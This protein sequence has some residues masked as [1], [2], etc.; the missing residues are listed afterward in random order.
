MAVAGEIVIELVADNGKMKMAV[1]DAQT[2]IRQFETS[3][4]QTARSVKRL[5]DAQFSLSTKFR[6]LVMTLGNL[7]FAL[8]DINDVFIRLPANIMKNAGELERLQTLMKGLSTEVTDLGKAM[9]GQNSFNFVTE[10]AKKAPFEIS[11]ISDAFVKLKTA[12]IDPTNGSLSAMIDSVARFGGSNEQLKRAT[13]AIQQ[14]AGKGVISMEELRQQLGEAVPTAMKAMA[15]SMGLSMGELAKQVSTGTLQAEAPLRKML[16]RL[17]IENEG[18]AEAMMETWVG[19]LSQLKTEWMLASKTIADAGFGDAAKEAVDEIKTALQSDEFKVF[20]REFGQTLGQTIRA[21]SAAVKFVIEYKDAILSLGAAFAAYKTVHSLALPM[22]DSMGKAYRA[23]RE[24]IAT[25]KNQKLGEVAAARTAAGEKIAALNQESAAQMRTTAQNIAAMQREAEFRR[26]MAA[27][28]RA[29]IDRLANPILAGERAR[30]ANGRFV[31]TESVRAQVREIERIERAHKSAATGIEQSLLV[32]QRAHA[33]A[34]LNV[35]Q[36][37]A[38]VDALAASNRRAGA[39]ATAAAIAQRAMGGVWNLI[40]G[41]SGLAVLAIMAV[42]SAWYKVAD[43]A[44]EAKAA[45]SREDKNESTEDDLKDR[46]KQLADARKEL[47]LYT[48]AVREHNTTIAGRKK[49]DVEKDFD[50]KKVQELTSKV[51]QLEASVQKRMAAVTESAVKDRTEAYASNVE[52]ELRAMQDGARKR[53]AQER[54]T[55]AERLEGLQKDSKEYTAAVKENVARENKAFLD[56]QTRQAKLLEDRANALEEQAGRNRGSSTEERAGMRRAADQL[57]EKAKQ[58]RDQ[59]ATDLKTIEM[60]VIGGGGKDGKGG[61]GG[62]KDTPLQRALE[63]LKIDRAGFEEEIEG[64]RSTMGKA[65]IVAVAV[66]K[67]QAR[68]DAGDFGSLSEGEKKS[69]LDAVRATFGSKKQAE[70]LREVVETT[71]Q[72]TSRAEQLAERFSE[73]LGVF[74]DPLGTGR[75]GQDETALDKMIAKLGDKLPAALDRAGI[76]L[77]QLRSQAVTSDASRAF[78]D[79]ARQ[80]QQLEGELTATTRAGILERRRIET[81]SHREKMQE[82]IDRMWLEGAA[83]ETIQQAQNLLDR[84]VAARNKAAAEEAKTPMQKLLAEWSNTTE[85][86][87]NASASWATS[88]ADYLT[89]LVMGGKASFKDLANSIIQDLVRIQIQ[90]AMVSAISA[91]TSFFFADGGIMSASGPLPLKQ[92]AKGGIANSPQL[93]VFGEGSM[94]EAFVPL[95]DGRSIPVTLS[96]GAGGA[97][98]QI[99]IEVNQSGEKSSV[100]GADSGAW[101]RMAD[102]VKTVVREELAMQQRPG[103][104][105][106]R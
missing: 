63:R 40:G 62:D 85:A 101:M 21:I 81:A 51:A 61:N 68:I 90:K 91:A 96:G 55:S 25:L 89:T 17:R 78:E 8:M 42:A 58:I 48:K 3:V 80:T 27:Q 93:A 13:I 102:R 105:L 28:A 84:N 14:M 65:D 74:A 106:Y 24:E 87:E 29:E 26:A 60:P 38:A 69:L 5:E 49:S 104:S 57:R 83:I 86:M 10:Q 66:A 73:A 9:D 15:D 44:R 100:N 41:W 19:K 18:A 16:L 47:E 77:Q 20:A 98:V 43:A 64:L 92:Y 6:H 67:F 37:G 30:G 72:V 45:Q 23:Q 97:G 76:S 95:P 35:M 52:V 54:K 53:M 11:A 22:I 12:G 56:E 4:N 79:L 32:A 33:Q 34:A 88:T 59:V 50:L 75:K 103:G 36:N 99:N 1:K 82:L 7:R 70:E 94:N 46:Q 31:S 39:A 71:Q 2:V